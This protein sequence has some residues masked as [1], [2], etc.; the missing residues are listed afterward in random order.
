[1]VER[2]NTN[3]WVSRLVHTAAIAGIIVGSCLGKDNATASINSEVGSLTTEPVLLILD[4]SRPIDMLR[5]ERW[6]LGRVWPGV[7][8]SPE[9]L[10][11]ALD[12]NNIPP[13]ILLTTTIETDG[14]AEGCAYNYPDT[15]TCHEISRLKPNKSSYL[16]ETSVLD[17]GRVY[18]ELGS[19]RLRP[20][21]KPGTFTITME[22]TDETAQGL[23]A[24]ASTALEVVRVFRQYIPSIRKGA[25]FD[26]RLYLPHIQQG[27]F[28]ELLNAK[29]DRRENRVDR[30]KIKE[31]SWQKRAA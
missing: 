7:D 21:D 29:A 8:V 18:G 9:M 6:N 25:S 2:R 17:P 31:R 12:K 23:I 5:Y 11:K 28:L 14:L 13:K 10:A 4:P 24:S 26:N 3:K 16:F 22:L 27:T 1:M 15:K 19:A 20:F 30:W